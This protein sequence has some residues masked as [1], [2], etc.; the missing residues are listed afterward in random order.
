MSH[1]ATIAT[2]INDLECL[3][4]ALQEIGLTN[5]EVHEDPQFIRNYYGGHENKAHVVITYPKAKAQIGFVRNEAGQYSIIEDAYETNQYIGYD[6][7]KNMLIPKYV[8]HVVTA[9]AE[10]MRSKHG[11]YKI[12]ESI[13]ENGDYKFRVRFDNKQKQVARR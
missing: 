11:A 8:R 6:F 3:L 4:K 10:K 2:Q 12:E 9:Q 1:F 7:L 5:I 13:E